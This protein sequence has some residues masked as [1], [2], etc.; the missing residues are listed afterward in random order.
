MLLRHKTKLHQTL[1]E[2]TTSNIRQ[3][4]TF[5]SNLVL[6]WRKVKLR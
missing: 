1:D 2:N 3:K 4:T 6:Y 5:V